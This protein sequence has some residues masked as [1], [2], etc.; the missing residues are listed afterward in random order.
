MYYYEVWVADN[1]FKGAGALTY[2]SELVLAVGSVVEVFIRQKK[3]LAIVTKTVAKPKF[4]TKPLSAT[5]V[6][7]PIPAQLLAL[8]QWMPSYYPA[9]AGETLQQFLP[10]KLYPPDEA[11]LTVKPTP[12]PSFEL[13]P[14]TAEQQ[15]VIGEISKPDTYVLHGETGS[16]KTRVYVE[17]ALQQ[18]KAGRSSI[19][20]TPEIGLT[21]QLTQTFIRT[22]GTDN[23]ITT[24]SQLTAKQRSL[25]WNRA[26]YAADNG[27]R[28]LPLVVLGPRS[29]LFMPLHDV[30]LIILDESH[31]A[32]YKQEQ[33]PHYHAAKVAAKL[34]TLHQ[35]TLILGSATP[36]VADYYIAQAKG[37]KILRMTAAATTS[38]FEAATVEIIDLKDRAAFSRKPNL[39][40]ALLKGVEA[41]LKAGEQSLIFLNRRGTART[42]LCEK[43]GWM[44]M[45]GHCDLPLTYHGDAHNLRCHTC[46]LVTRAF[47]SCPECESPHILMK[48]IGTKAIV[49]ELQSA[50]PQASIQRFDTDNSKSERL[51]AHYHDVRD[52]K[53]DI[54]VGTQIIAKG[55]DLPGLSTVGIVVADTSLYL[56]D[57]SAQERTYQL[58]RQV[59]GRVGRGH[60]AGRIIL[61][62]YD[63]G[64]PVIMAAAAGDWD[65]F[66]AAELEERR[67]F[68]FP[69]FC[70]TLKLS[71]RRASIKS[72]ETA[73][74]KTADSLRN[75]GLRV[76]VDG[77]MPAL[78]EKH[79]DKYQ[80]QLNLKSKDRGE[81]VKAVRILP[82]N[83]SYDID[84]SNLL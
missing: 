63:P 31:E 14:L 12:L 70:Y 13:P 58:L 77:P 47:T 29:A 38:E 49:E 67:M 30:G 53:V 20:L 35:A 18:L 71:C 62:T 76:I 23:V 1:S 82:A 8:A 75:S 44:A 55:L 17:L 9:S 7:R 60:R 56:P 65:G 4:A 32:S 37:K 42:V 81:L 26:Q 52:G 83:W 19:V 22:F 21:P 80:W 6:T 2:Q 51:E 11:L 34:A 40:D 79:G 33:A 74:I 68:T 10:T 41:S 16:G 15:A 27:K 72:A 48:S 78:H 73:A 43:C 61:Q 5:V 54:V 24:H 57:Y 45:C 3:V 46:G 69:P 36:S 84:P 64:S 25:Q 39:S 66:Y 50:F 59:I 28:P